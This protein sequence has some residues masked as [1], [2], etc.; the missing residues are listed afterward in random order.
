MTAT[1]KKKLIEA[2]LPLPEIN[3]ASAYD[4]MPGIGPHPKG[5]HHWWARLPLPTARAILFAS[6]VDDPEAHPE[7]WPTEE[8]QNAERERL[9][10]ILRRMMGK[11]LHEAPEVYAEAQAEM[12][13]HCDGKLPAIF[14]P[15]SGGGSIPLE[16]NRLGFEAHAG[17][18]NPVAVLLNKC[19]LE[20]APRWTDQPPVNPSDRKRFGGGEAWLGTDGLAADIRYYGHQMLSGVKE[21]FGRHY[22]RVTLPRAL[23]GKDADVVAWIWARTVISP[24][25]AAKGNRV[26]LLS[27]Y[28]LSNKKGSEIWLNPIVDKENSSVQ[29]EIVEGRPDD[30]RRV[31]GGNKLGRGANFECLLTGQPISDEYVK[32]EG[33]AGR[34]GTQMIAIVADGGRRRV[35]LPADQSQSEAATFEDRP[36]ISSGDMPDNAR[37]FSPP[38]FGF[39]TYTSIFTDRQMWGLS[40]LVEQLHPIE[41]EVVQDALKAGISTE[42]ATEYGKSIRT[43]LA[44]AIDRTTDFNNSICRWSPSNQKVMNLFGRQAIPMV[45]DFAEANLLGGSVG[46]WLTCF[47]YVADC[48]RTITAGSK[49][50]GTARQIDAATGANGISNLMV[51]TDPPYYDNI[52]YAA[53]SDFFYVWLRRSLGR[54]YDELFSTMMVPKLPELTASPERFDGD[55]VRAKEHFE[56]GFRSAFTALRQKMDHRFPLTVYYA[57]K[58]DDEESGSDSDSGTDTIDLTTGWETL[59]EALISSGFQITGTWP[60]RA[61]Q[62][63]RMVSMGTNALASYIVLACRPRPDDAPQI[64]SN[65]FRNELKRTLPAALRHLQQGNIAPVDF[66]QAAIGPGMAV[67]SRYSRILEPSGRPMTVRTALGIINQTLTEVLSELEDDFDSDTR[68]AIAWFEQNGFTAG[69]YG[70]AELLSKAKVTAVSGLVQAGIV[71]SKGGKVRLLSPAEL[72]ADWD[73]SGD[74]RLTVWEMTHHLLRL[75]HFDKAGDEATAALLR[76]LGNQ[77]E[78]AR[79]LAYRLHNISERKKWSQEAQGYNALVLGWPEIA[80]LAREMPV[81]APVTPAQGT[82]I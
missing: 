36:E 57:F 76:K 18:L 12:L 44:L 23:G 46:A 38:L 65:Q 30:V 77:G 64:A 69:D 54:S 50:R 15:F 25:P 79:E 42:D 9:F 73:P 39:L 58:Q 28:W 11:K 27:S 71:E 14:D 34:L 49:K 82:L 66:A 26:P 75:Y 40:G 48:V 10:D 59:L 3:D 51:S 74:K 20:I 32:A 70:D 62:K 24:N 52:G 2:A 6:V 31:A 1:H 43:F 16:A 19:N 78:V 47:D 35:Y 60:V 7:K 67:Y 61:S 33:L 63:W 41:K 17:D 13:K 29:F 37:W 45:W 53:L 56:Q 81:A 68:W 5:I 4:K 21:K 22:P 72:P 55:K 8:E 80:R